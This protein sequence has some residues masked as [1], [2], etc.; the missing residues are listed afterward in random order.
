MAAVPSFRALFVAMALAVLAAC[1]APAVPA[2]PALDP[3]PVLLVASRF[4]SAHGRGPLLVKLALHRD[5]MM[6]EAG[7]EERAFH[8]RRLAPTEVAALVAEAAALIDSVKPAERDQLVLAR[9]VP[10]SEHNFLVVISNGRARFLRLKGDLAGSLSQPDLRSSDAA[11]RATAF[12]RRLYDAG[13]ASRTK[14]A[15][16]EF[17]VDFTLAS[18][19]AKDGPACTIPHD[20]PAIDV[21]QQVIDGCERPSTAGSSVNLS[22]L[23]PAAGVVLSAQHWDA[24]WSW[25][26]GCPAREVLM[27]G[28]RFTFAVQLVWPGDS[29]WRDIVDGRVRPQ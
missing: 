27:G 17:Q 29:S 21:D 22:C 26:D 9:Q 14:A 18:E 13:A 7:P 5:G 23:I 12:F 6:L 25:Q 20:W 11:D 3:E 24:F 15:P 16:A 4:V 19:S 2:R 10:P 28:R 8:E 1:A